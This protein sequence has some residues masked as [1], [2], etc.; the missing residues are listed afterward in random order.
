MIALCWL[1]QHLQ[2]AVAHNLLENA[3]TVISRLVRLSVWNIFH[4]KSCS[5]HLPESDTYFSE[6]KLALEIA[7]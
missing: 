6:T 4:F 3:T 2:A 7:K 1:L 5:F